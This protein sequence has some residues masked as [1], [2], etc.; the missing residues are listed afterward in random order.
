MGIDYCDFSDA[1]LLLETAKGDDC[2]FAELI[3]R[4]Q[5]ALFGFFIRSGAQSDLA[6]DL[7]Q[8]TFIKIYRYAE[9]YRE[10]AKFTTFLF[11]VARNCWIDNIRKK[12]NQG[13]W[14]LLEE[15]AYFAPVEF[16][17]TENMEK[18]ELDG[19]VSTLI[20]QLPQKQRDTLILSEELD[21][22]YNEIAEILQIPV[23]TVKSRI[24]NAINTIREGLLDK[25]LL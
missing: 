19:A 22:K 1:D 14:V 24:F 12:R 23:G 18:S 16:N 25:G 17:P 21:L 15:D 7:V 5:N 13:D 20:N 10:T 2:A 4:Y 11:K 9:K 8:E 3:T 6:E